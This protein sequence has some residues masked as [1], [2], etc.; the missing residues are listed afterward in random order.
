MSEDDLNIAELHRRLHPEGR[1]PR[2]PEEWAAFFATGHALVEQY[3]ADRIGPMINELMSL[4]LA[5]ANVF[6]GKLLDALGGEPPA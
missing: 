2:T 4:T 6:L 5:T 3:G 1:A